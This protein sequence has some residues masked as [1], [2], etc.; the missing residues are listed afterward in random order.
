MRRR[1]KKPTIYDLSVLAGHSASTVSAVMNGTWRKRRISEKTAES[2]LKLADQHAYTANRQAQGLRSS[3]SGLVGLL[4]PLHDNR[5]FSAMAQ[6]FE[7]QVRSRGLCPVV[8]SANRDPEEERATV[9]ALISYSIDALFICGATDP[10]SLHELCTAAGLPHVNVDLPGTKVSSVTTDNY[11]GGRALTEA[12]IRQFMNADVEPL[13]GRDLFLIGGRDDDA[14]RERI[15]GFHDAKRM[16]LNDDPEGCVRVLGYSATNTK[17]VV[18]ELF[19]REGRLPRALFVNSSI[20]FEGVLRFMA[21]HPTQDYADL[22]VGCY[23]YD[24]FAS[25][26]SFPVIMIRQDVDAILSKAFEIMEHPPE[27]PVLHRIK[28]ELI[29][30]RTALSGPLDALKN[31]A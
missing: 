4:L 25:F 15:R 26:L 8:V 2:I 28:P 1:L 24:P 11:G 12:I 13:S 19:A 31:I 29:P 30:P 21:E 7:A 17:L 27:T 14:T 16:L 22:V 20:N 23:D 9:S 3:R 10:D 6:A 18:E 5:F